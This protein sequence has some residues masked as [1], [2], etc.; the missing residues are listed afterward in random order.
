MSDTRHDERAVEFHVRVLGYREE[1]EWV[2]LALEMNLHGWGETWEEALR[3][4]AGRI[5]AQV[6]AALEDGKPEAIFFPAAPEWF[7]RWNQLLPS[8]I[9]SSAANRPAA[10]DDFNLAELPILMSPPKTPMVLAH[11]V[12]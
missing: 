9:A 1:G 12:G 11:A 5:D 8:R 3:V 7:E 4:L 2:A 10:D 6:A